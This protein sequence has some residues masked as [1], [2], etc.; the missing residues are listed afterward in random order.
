[1]GG[2]PSFSSWQQLAGDPW[3]NYF[4]S[5]YGSV[6]NTGFPLCIGDFWMFYDNLVAQH[7]VKIPKSVGACPNVNQA[8]SRYTNNN[9][10]S[11]PGVSWSWHPIPFQPFAANS[12]V[13]VIHR[14]DPWGDEH[15]GVWFF[16]AKGSGVWFNI[17][18]TIHFND[19]GAGWIH[20]RA[21][22]G[23]GA[24][25]Q[26][27][28]TNAAKG[29]YKSI[30]FMAHSDGGIYDNCR[31]N[32]KSPY[33]NIEIVGTAGYGENTCA[34]KTGTWSELYVGWQGGGGPC[35]CDTSASDLNCNKGAITNMTELV[36]DAVLESVWP[37]QI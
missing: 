29:G 26:R 15:S 33:L 18:K 3:G 30:Q 12:W 1:M 8:G 27:M 5:L 31:K 13:E 2:W 11:P 32:S 22:G 16:N 20:F 19:H 21:G 34:A 14:K 9:K 6:P 17:G 28:C 10:I 37:L 7:G 4:K 23:G 36:M 25:N 35:K 24:A